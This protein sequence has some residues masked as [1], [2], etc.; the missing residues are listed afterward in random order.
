[1]DTL[2]ITQSLLIALWVAAVMSR[3]L[4]GGATLT[5]RFSPLMTGLIVGIV[6]GD[7]K[8]AMIVTAALQMIY[9]GV[10]APGGSMPAEP[11][12][13]AAIAVPVALLGNL[14]AEAAIAVAVPVG[15][16][17]SYLYQ[18][19]FF[20][21]TFLGK[22]TDK[23]VEDLNAKAMSRSIILYPTLASFILYVPLIFISLYFGA[24]LIAD[25]INALEGTVVIHILEVVGG[26]LAAIGIAT[27]VYV[28]GRKDYMVFFF[29][30]YFMSVVLSSLE[31]T[32][33]TYSIF[34]ILIAL[35][36]V[37]SQKGKIAPA[38]EK[39]SSTFEEDDDYDDGF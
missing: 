36:F 19:R 16:L 25:V 28:I 2:S 14:P 27:T 13:A 30:A 7:V 33:V 11:S 17:G 31:I 32:M 12:V 10:F 6:M 9:M 35:I 5:L 4:G 26:G 8:Q 20:I 3:W 37:Q 29:L 21:N 22:Y 18:F 1:M 39:A 23:A 15:L 38:A 24:P 34:G